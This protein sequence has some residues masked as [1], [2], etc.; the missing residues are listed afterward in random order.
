MV[1]ERYSDK[2]YLRP[3]KRFFP[4]KVKAHKKHEYVNFAL[5]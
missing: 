5:I 2:R 1:S 4:V 3:R